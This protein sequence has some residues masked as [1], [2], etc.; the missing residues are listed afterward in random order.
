MKWLCKFI[1]PFVP[2]SA[3][4][5]ERRVN[6]VPTDDFITV[7]NATSTG[8]PTVTT[9][10]SVQSGTG[11]AGTTVRRCSATTTSTAGE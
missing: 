7:R 3:T 6:A 8:Y 1:V 2:D 9:T 5:N 4:S 11:S 10:D